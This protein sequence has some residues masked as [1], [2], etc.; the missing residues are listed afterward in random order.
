LSTNGTS[1]LGTSPDL[2]C[3]SNH[4]QLATAPPPTAPTGAALAGGLET[5]QSHTN[6]A[7]AVLRVRRRPAHA[8]PGAFSLSA[9]RPVRSPLWLGVNSSG[10][11]R[12]F[13]RA[14]NRWWSRRNYRV[15]CPG[16]V[17]VSGGC[18]RESKRVVRAAAAQL[19]AR[20]PPTLLLAQEF[21]CEVPM[22]SCPPVGALPRQRRL[23]ITLRCHAPTDASATE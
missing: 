3:R 23:E 4:E 6:L 12:R 21:R 17:F 16:I 15:A 14:G 7:R 8:S 5:S 10:S 19:S 22:W 20:E 1:A 9:V 18:S 2:P 13:L 11:T